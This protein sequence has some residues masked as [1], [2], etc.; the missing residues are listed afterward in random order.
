MSVSGYKL[1]DTKSWL[2]Y[3]HFRHFFDESPCSISI[4]DEI[5]VT[6]LRDACREEKISFY[7][8]M[9]YAV[10]SV[11][12]SHEEF[13]LT[14]VDL[15]ES[16][17]LMPAVWE[18]VDIVHNVFHEDSKTYTGTFT[19]WNP[20]FLTFLRNC[21]EDIERS[22]NLRIMSIP[23]GNNVFEASCVPWRH[24]S[25]IGIVT[26]PIWL[27]P[28]VAW[29]G[30]REIGGKTFMPLSIQIHHAAADGYHLARFLNETEALA[31]DLSRY[32]KGRKTI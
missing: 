22:K 10:A 1:I 16:D 5:D 30:F 31:A 27:S 20:D 2:R 29:G 19:L 25:S 26:E 6:S 11:V 12:N 15:R 9:L 3:E 24:F 23:C 17:H 14:A 4:C 18:R 8:A 21:S 7:T 13:M 32:I 28:I